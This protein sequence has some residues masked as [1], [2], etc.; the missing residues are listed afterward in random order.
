MLFSRN[1]FCVLAKGGTIAQLTFS[2]TGTM[3]DDG[4]H[5]ERD[6]D[7]APLYPFSFLRSPTVLRV[8]SPYD[9]TCLGAGA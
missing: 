6:A 7:Q 1:T 9:N 4:I 5:R 3:S 8:M 2:H